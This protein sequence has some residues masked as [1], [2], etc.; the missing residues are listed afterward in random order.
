MRIS[1]VYL[2]DI[3]RRASKHLSPT[4]AHDVIQAAGHRRRARIQLR[5]AAVT[6]S[7]CILTTV[8]AHWVRT[9]LA[10]RRNLE[11]WSRMAAQVRVLEESI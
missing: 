10:E 1:K 2:E 11:A 7:I 9:E 3:R 4:F 6:V 8:G 5:I